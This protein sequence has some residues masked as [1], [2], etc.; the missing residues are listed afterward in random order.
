MVSQGTWRTT[1]RAFFVVVGFFSCFL[2]F[3]RSFL[4][5]VFSHLFVSHYDQF[6]RTTVVLVVQ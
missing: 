3:F 1:T 5:I 4:T 6:L 2:S